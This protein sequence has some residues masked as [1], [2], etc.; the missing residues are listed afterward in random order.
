MYTFDIIDIPDNAVNITLIPI[1]DSYDEYQIVY[2]IPVDNQ[3][4]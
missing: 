1:E 2:L 4:K 3:T